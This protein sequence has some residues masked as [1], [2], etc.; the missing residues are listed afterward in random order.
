M[1]TVV[2]VIVLYLVILVGLRIL[3]KREFGQLSPL[4]LITLLLVPELVSQAALRSDYSLTTGIV[5]ITTL[6]SLVFLTSVISH[7]SKRVERWISG[8]P[9]VLVARGQLLM[10]NLNR[11][12]ISPDEIYSEMHKAGL[13]RIKQVKWALLETDGRIA[14]VEEKEPTSSASLA[15]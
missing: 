9:T 1:E 8:T 12:R 13:E 7:R 4:E 15:G 11:E 6:F 5:A 3:G 14:L 2:R 10:D